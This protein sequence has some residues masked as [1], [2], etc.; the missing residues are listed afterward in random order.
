MLRTAAIVVAWKCLCNIDGQDK[1]ESRREADV[2]DDRVGATAD[3]NAMCHWKL[4]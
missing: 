4:Q 1:L 2:R 3:A